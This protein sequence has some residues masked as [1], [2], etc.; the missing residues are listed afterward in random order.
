MKQNW[1]LLKI[2]RREN[3]AF[4]RTCVWASQGKDCLSVWAVDWSCWWSQVTPHR[5]GKNYFSSLFVKWDSR[6]VPEVPWM[7]FQS[8]A[9]R[10]A[11]GVRSCPSTVCHWGFWWESELQ[12]VMGRPQ[13][14]VSCVG[15]VCVCVCA[16]WVLVYMVY[17]DHMFTFDVQSNSLSFSYAH[18]TS[19]F[20]FSL[21][22]N[23][24]GR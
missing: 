19:Y 17:G 9:T 1:R 24:L 16:M 12:G 5:V 2:E 14:N 11:Q 4:L 15:F 10:V 8:G 23:S 18:P 13:A 22:W 3:K 7:G 6:V 20:L 21:T